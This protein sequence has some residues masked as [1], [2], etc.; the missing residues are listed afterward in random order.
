MRKRLITIF[1]IRFDRIINR[2]KQHLITFQSILGRWVIFD[3]IV[4]RYIEFLRNTIETFTLSNLIDIGFLAIHCFAREILYLRIQHHCDTAQYA[5]YDC[6][7][8]HIEHIFIQV[9]IRA[10]LQI[11]HCF[12]MKISERFTFYTFLN[13]QTSN[14]QPY[15]A[16]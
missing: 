13:P 4:F 6:L 9:N 16:F 8:I 15:I 5:C 2:D 11:N 14:R 10:K 1:F 3:N 12:T 7:Y